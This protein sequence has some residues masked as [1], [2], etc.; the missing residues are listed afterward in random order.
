MGDQVDTTSYSSETEE[1]NN[2]IPT[3]S[4]GGSGS[5]PT[6][7]YTFDDQES[8]VSQVE[9]NGSLFGLELQPVA[10]TPTDAFGLFAGLETQSQNTPKDDPFGLFGATT[11]SPTEDLFGNK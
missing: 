4:D 5:E 11:P 8:S 2:S 10:Q 1:D 7:Y 6:G 9:Q 3:T